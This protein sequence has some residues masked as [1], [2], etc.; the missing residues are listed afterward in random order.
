MKRKIIR[1]SITLNGKDETFTADGMN[2]L[3]STGFAVSCNLA[4]GNGAI[5]PS[6]QITIYGL[7]MEKMLKL[8]RVQWNTMDALLN[9][10]TVEVG[11]DTNN[12]AVAYRGNI[13]QATIEANSAP[14]IPLIITSQMA[15]VEKA[16]VEPPYTSPK[17]ESVNIADLVKTFADQIK[18]E[19]QNNGVENVGTDITLEGSTLEKIQKLATIFDFDLYTDDNL[20]AICEKGRARTV[21]IPVITPS[22]GLI[23]YPVPDI[24]G[25]SFNCLYDPLVKF[26]GIVHVDGSIITVCNG[27]WRIYGYSAQ[28]ESN[29]PNGK[30]QISAQ[31]TWRHSKDVAIAK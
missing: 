23:G 13:T 6:A 21:K 27:Y 26:G 10:V 11:D 31:A 14:D 1:V 9:I 12:L 22:T 8:M 3:S 30:W 28:L 20:I 17:G 5:T 19:F 24:K 29:I 4:Y 15:M 16:K 2:K 7:P 18:Y 25:M